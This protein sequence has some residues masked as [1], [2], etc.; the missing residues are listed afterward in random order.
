MALSGD[1]AS[2]LAGGGEFLLDPG[3]AG[4]LGSVTIDYK[5]YGVGLAFTPTVLKA[6]LI[7]LKIEPEVSQLDTR[8]PVTRSRASTVPPLIVRRAS[9]HDRVARRPGASRWAAPPAEPEHDRAG[10]IAL[11]RRCAG[12]R[13]PCSRSSAYQKNE[14]DLAIIV[15][16]HLV[17][18]IAP[19]TPIKTPLDNTLPANDID[20][21]LMG[22]SEITPADA[23]MAVGQ[24]Q[25]N[26][27]HIL[28]LPKGVANVVAVKNY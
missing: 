22:K 8:H 23:R 5:R 1:T 3:A 18:P 19:G 15:T 26:V 12:A 2:F 11:D 13:A 4:S 14:T 24:Q 10:A 20:F 16:P 6:G 28:D 7:N 17:R 9:D 21:F 27:G 25:R